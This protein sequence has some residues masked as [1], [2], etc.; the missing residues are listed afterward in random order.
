MTSS[1]PPATKPGPSGAVR[2]ALVLPERYRDL[3]RIAR[4][5]WGEVRRVHDRVVDRVVAMKILAW[6]HLDSSFVRSRFMNEARITAALAHPG[7]VP[8]HDQGVLDDGRPWFTM[9]AIDGPTL[10]ALLR[11]VGARDPDAR[12]AFTRRAL[13]ALV[14]V[15]ET[16]GFAHSQHIVHRDLK[17]SNLMLGAFGEVLVLDWGIARYAQ[18]RT[19]E[20][21]DARDA[22]GGPELGTGVVGTAAYMSPEQ[23]RGEPVGPPSDVYSLGLV[24]YHVLTGRAPRVGTDAEVWGMALHG[25]APMLSDGTVPDELAAIYARAVQA[26][27]RARYAD[28]GELAAALRAYLDGEAKR[29]RAD[30]W[31]RRA[32]ELEIE[33]RDLRERMESL[34]QR[35]HALRAELREHDP[36]SKKK[37]VWALEDDVAALE[38]RVALLDTERLE[39][40]RLALQEHPE[41]AEAHREL[42]RAYRAAVV[43][44][45][46]EHRH[47]DASAFE[48]LLRRHDRGEHTRFLEGRGRVSLATDPPGARVFARRYDVVDRRLVLGPA[49]EIGSTPLRE[50]ELPA[51]SYV[52]EVRRKGFAPMRYPVR[53]GRDETW[54]PVRPGDGEPTPVPLLAELG[55]DEAYVPAGWAV[56]GGDPQASEPVPRARR[57][58]DGFVMQRT[59]VTM[60]QYLAFL[61]DLVAQGERARAEELAP[62]VMRG[63]ADEHADVRAMVLEG[64]RFRLLPDEW[65]HEPDLR[66]PVA[67]VDWYAATA[68]ARWLAART[69]LPWRLPNELEWEKAGRGVDER[70]YPWG[71]QAE[72][73]W[74]CILGSTATPPSR[75]PVDAYPTDESPYGVRGLAGNVRDWCINVWRGD[76]PVQ[77]DGIV[78]IDAADDGDEAPRAIRG[79]AWATVPVFARLAGRFAARPREHFGVVGFRLVRSVS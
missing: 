71:A 18:P 30:A 23:A 70:A 14:R 31:V 42:A 73:T 24:L 69:G 78:M 54:D 1:M 28:A 49:W 41:H 20:E 32:A 25:E 79:G 38:R 51:G 8:V 45:E 17:P 67:S 75:V 13:E 47:A 55:D 11:D 21:D 4:G 52:L 48:L 5:G 3:G 46:A 44:A 34:R 77:R 53:I 66:W 15:C 6:E 59:A 63:A 10:D 35:A 68:Y 62:R 29:A 60:G 57:W 64:D 37:P 33:A 72:P 27:P 7:V 43:A 2:S 36:V 61:N 16:V 76:G 56:L 9:K 40:L 26:N 39:S 12:S 58:I 22:P 50:V 65:G 74:A 19:G